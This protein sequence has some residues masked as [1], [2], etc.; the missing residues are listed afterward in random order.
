VIAGFCKGPMPGY[1]LW[2]PGLR[3]GLFVPIDLEKHLQPFSN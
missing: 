2:R 1:W 3:E